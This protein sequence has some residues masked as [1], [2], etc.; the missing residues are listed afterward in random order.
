MA[1][2]NLSGKHV[3]RYEIKSRLGRGERGVVYRA[4]HPSVNRMLAV[5]VWPASLAR[6]ERFQERFQ[7]EVR[8]I[9]ALNHFHIVPI[10]GAGLWEGLPYLVM[11]Y[12]PGGSLADL[13]ARYEVLTVGELLP[14]LEQVAEALDYAHQHGVLHRNLKPTNILLD[15]EGNAYLTDFGMESVM[16][17]ADH[18][19]LSAIPAYRAPEVTRGEA[20]GPAADVYAL[21]VLAFRAL[22]GQMPYR[23]DTPEE[24]AQMHVDQPIPSLRTINA[25]I[26]APVEA[27]VR[28]AL[29]KEPSARYS[30]AGEFA[31]ALATAAQLQP[32]ARERATMGVL[33]GRGDLP[34]HMTPPPMPSPLR[35]MTPP[36]ISRR[37]TE[38]GTALL[39]RDET[40]RLRTETQPR[41][42]PAV[43]AERRHGF[44][45]YT[46][47]LVLFM[48]IVVWMAAGVL[49]GAEARRQ[50][51]QIALA[52]IHDTQTPAA[53][54][55]S[56]EI[57]ATAEAY[58]GALAAATQFAAQTATAAVP[59][60]TPTPTIT[61]SPTP[62]LTPTPLAGSGGRI[63]YVSEA[64][65]DPEIVVLDL[66]D[67][68]RTQITRNTV[69]DDLPSWSPDGQLIAFQSALAPE[70]QHIYV[71]DAG[72]ASAESCAESLRQLTSGYRVDTAP[73]WSPDGERLVF[74]SHEGG[75]WWIRSVTLAGEQQDLTQLPGEIHLYEWLPNDVLT[76]YGVSVDGV[77]EILRLGVGGRSVDRQALTDAVGAVKSADFSPDGKQV[78]YEALVGNVRQLFLADASCRYFN[79]CVIRRLTEDGFNYIRPRFSPDGTLIL[80][81][82]DRGGNL[83]LYVMDLTGQIVQ[84]LTESPFDEYHGEWQPK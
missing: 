65:G 69:R 49:L 2:E 10:Y 40:G 55:Y 28:R 4:Y 58:T 61:P 31:R 81:A 32:T 13:L 8:T 80:V 43:A 83:D 5:K 34:I 1:E 30:S 9:A 11:R 7:Q 60:L 48:L 77:Y 38:E 52:R 54:T 36:P 6:G 57:T 67:G 70:G 14:M 74:F 19:P 26:N 56:A 33:R 29:A 27:A 51:N 68:T 20:A 53:A 25:S 78:V 35:A 39:P 3:E 75:R 62:T 21:G 12:L 46:V 16:G 50:I 73:L 66:A 41:S 22:T 23:A 84:R 71:V 64:D 63:V 47:V 24:L 44:A 17:D 59:T 42:R 45:W 37:T 18:Q 82:S 72:C 15:E 76:F 79:R